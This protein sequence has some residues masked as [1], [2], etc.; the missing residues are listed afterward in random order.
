MEKLIGRIVGQHVYVTGKDG[1]R[2]KRF[3]YFVETEPGKW[4]EIV[5]EGEPPYQQSVTLH[6]LIDKRC[7]VEG[8]KFQTRFIVQKENIKEIK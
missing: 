7:Q 2:E 6:P 4:K 8:D 3:H 5:V 1:K